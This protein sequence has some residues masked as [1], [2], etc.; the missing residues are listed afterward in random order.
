MPSPSPSGSAAVTKMVTTSPG[1]G[2]L[3]DLLGLDAYD[4]PE[5]FIA[6]CRELLLSPEAAAAE[7][8]RLHDAN[9][10]HWDSRAPHRSLAAW[11]GDVGP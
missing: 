9:R 8:A 10:T 4:D 11:L 5:S 7:A 2:S 3:A 1:V 6:R